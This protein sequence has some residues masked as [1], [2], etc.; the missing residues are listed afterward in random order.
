VGVYARTVLRE[1]LAVVADSPDLSEVLAGAGVDGET[2]GCLVP[3]VVGL[4]GLGVG[5]AARAR[6]GTG[7]GLAGLERVSAV[8]RGPARCCVMLHGRDT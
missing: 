4:L 3:A 8:L 5:M 1:M 2:L 7:P 6:T